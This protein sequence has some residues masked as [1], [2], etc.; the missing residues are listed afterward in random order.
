MPKKKL[1]SKKG[2]KLKNKDRRLKERAKNALNPQAPVKPAKEEGKIPQ[3]Y[4]SVT[5]MPSPGNAQ[6]WANPEGVNSFT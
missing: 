5:I 1:S 6:H 2:S 3:S 4:K